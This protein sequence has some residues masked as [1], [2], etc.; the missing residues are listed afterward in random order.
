MNSI[1]RYYLRGR[2]PNGFWGRRALN[3]MNGK[4]HAALPEWVLAE[5]NI[6]PEAR[7]L[8]VGCGGGANIARMLI[9]CPQGKVTGIDI[10]ELSIEVS[11]DLNFHAFVD[12]QCYLV[13]GNALQMPLARE[14]FDLVTAFETIYYWAS[15]ELGF[16]EI[17]R[18][19]KPNGRIVIAN[20][21]DGLQESDRDIEHATA[22]MRIYNIEE[23]TSELTDAG[24]INIQS[25]HDEKRR[26][27]CIT[28][29]KP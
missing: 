25:R 8:D 6:D 22:C 10:S 28:A 4:D 20:E 5:L 15:L 21:M 24:F 12:K 13:G 27:I 9:M 16:S 18:V 3:A 7:I 26:F 14:T 23:I 1:S 2:R 19:L 11:K 29:Q 17:F